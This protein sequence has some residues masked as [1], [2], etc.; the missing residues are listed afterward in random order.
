[1]KCTARRP[2][3]ALSVST[4]NCHGLPVW[5]N[6]KDTDIK[7]FTTQSVT[8][9]VLRK[10]QTRANLVPEEGDLSDTPINVES[11]SV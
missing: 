5:C 10:T 1:M 9:W 11:L 8:Q 2:V 3:L 4:S 6:P 7:F